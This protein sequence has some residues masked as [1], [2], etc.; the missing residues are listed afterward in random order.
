MYEAKR[1]FRDASWF[2]SST[3]ETM[4]GEI[5]RLRADEAAGGLVSS[6]RLDGP[7]FLPRLVM[8]SVVAACVN[9]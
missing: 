4:A 7:A 8:T 3:R 9:A 1:S 6:G 5:D 2:F